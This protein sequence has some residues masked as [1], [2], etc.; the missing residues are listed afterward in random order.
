[1]TRPQKIFFIVALIVALAV[2]GASAA[3]TFMMQKTYAGT[4]RVQWPGLPALV[5]PTAEAVPPQ[6]A[7]A[8][9]EPVLTQAALALNLNKLYG[10]RIRIDGDLKTWESVTLLKQRME[11]SPVSETNAMDIRV[12]DDDNEQAAKIANRIADVFCASPAA[13]TGG[14]H[15]VVATRAQV[16]TKPVRPNVPLNLA[17]GAFAGLIFGL[18]LGAGAAW[19]VSLIAKVEQLKRAKTA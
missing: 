1:M 17:L 11:I 19:T 10:K 6:M 2:F 8:Q 4:A 5:I 13:A 15:P 16:E 9:S 12:Y 18:A 14:V 7:A 3:F